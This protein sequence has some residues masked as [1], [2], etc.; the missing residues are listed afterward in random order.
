MK[1]NKDPY[2]LN[3]LS[4]GYG[5]GHK[6]ICWF[7]YTTNIVIV[8]YAMNLDGIRA[9]TLITV[10]HLNGPHKTPVIR[11]DRAQEQKK[12][13][14]TLQSVRRWHHTV[15]WHQAREQRARL[16]CKYNEFHFINIQMIWQINKSFYAYTM[17][18]Q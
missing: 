15:Q 2:R 7:T 9:I 17:R 6:Y 12:C 10:H 5:S 11:S 16:V 13:S 4:Y 14:V 3:F 8:T 18:L 1:L